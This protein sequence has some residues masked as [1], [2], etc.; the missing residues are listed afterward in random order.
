M[1]LLSFII[2]FLIKLYTW[3]PK[4]NLIP[5]S[6]YRLLLCLSRENHRMNR[7]DR[8]Y[9]EFL[10]FYLYFLRTTCILYLM[11][12]IGQD[13]PQTNQDISR[14]IRLKVVFYSYQIKEERVFYGCR[15]FRAYFSFNHRSHDSII[16]ANGGIYCSSRRSF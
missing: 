15:I 4:Y 14:R 12:P 2:T 9:D 10:S 16:G 5:L 11:E 3:I 1:F 8:I 6:I 13:L 7:F